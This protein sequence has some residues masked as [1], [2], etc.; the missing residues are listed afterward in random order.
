MQVQTLSTQSKIHSEVQAPSKSVKVENL[1]DHNESVTSKRVFAS[2]RH[3]P[4][5]AFQQLVDQLV[6]KQETACKAD[7]DSK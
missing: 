4:S 7:H 2:Y 5:E 6:A 3:Q 1:S